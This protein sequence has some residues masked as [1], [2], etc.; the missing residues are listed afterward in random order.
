MKTNI[1]ALMTLIAEL[2]KKINNLQYSVYEYTH[3]TV[4]KELDGRE[5]VV[6]DTKEDFLKTIEDFGLLLEQHA[7]LKATLLRK[8]SEFK[9]KDGRSIQEAIVDV[10]KLRKKK[11]LIEGLI[12]K[13]SSVKRYTEVNNS[14]FEHRTLNYDVKEYK[15]LLI[16]I[17]SEIQETEFE[18]S[19]LNSVE[20]YLD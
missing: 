9:L 10:T 19:K 11:G 8:N 16:E 15:E 3:T 6:E 7:T 13:R 18:I 2:E 17:D 14:Y 1:T 12:N 4:I 20:F 5:T